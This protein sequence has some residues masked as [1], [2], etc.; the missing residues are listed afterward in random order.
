MRVDEMTDEQRA[1][2]QRYVS[3]FE[4]YDMDAL[5]SVLRQDATMSMPPYALWLSGVDD[6]VAWHVGPGHGCRGSRTQLLTAN[7]LPAMATWKPREGGGYQPWSL[8]VVE[9]ER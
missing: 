1:L 6:I 5:V 4:R 7:G 9:P 3:A 8:V 2:L